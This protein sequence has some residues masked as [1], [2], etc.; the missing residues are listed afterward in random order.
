[1]FSSRHGPGPSRISGFPL[2][3]KTGS[4]VQTRRD[5]SLEALAS[6][7]NTATALGSRSADQSRRRVLFL[8][9]VWLSPPL[10]VSSSPVPFIPSHFDPMHTDYPQVLI[11]RAQLR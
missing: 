9:P 8:L 5:G 4:R 6:S 7:G 10:L 2:D 1:M 11:Q 3:N